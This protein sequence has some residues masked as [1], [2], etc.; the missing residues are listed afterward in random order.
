MFQKQT[1]TKMNKKTIKISISN[2]APERNS[3]REKKK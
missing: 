2:M 1:P 3:N